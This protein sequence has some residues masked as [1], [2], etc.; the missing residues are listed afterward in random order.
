MLSCR[1]HQIISGISS[2]IF[3]PLQGVLSDCYGHFM[4]LS[5]FIVVVSSTG[6]P[7][8]IDTHSAFEDG[9]TSIS[10]GSQVASFLNTPLM[11]AL[12]EDLC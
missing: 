11:F 10:L 4:G 1:V 3:L 8:H 7:P 6:I 2:K 9:I 12:S 5:L